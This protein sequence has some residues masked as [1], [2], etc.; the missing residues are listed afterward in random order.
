MTSNYKVKVNPASVGLFQGMSHKEA[1][2]W[3]LT[4]KYRMMEYSAVADTILLS[5]LYYL[6]T[7]EGYGPL[8]LR[9]AWEGM[10]RVRAVARVDM[11]ELSSGK[12]YKLEATGKNVEDFYMRE[13]LRKR[14]CDLK[15]WERDTRI[16]SEGVVIFGPWEP[17]AKRK[18]G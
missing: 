16:T 10:V 13:E 11:R 8:R 14:G 6:A 2:A 12:E 5:M 7:E 3:D 17:P 9:R 15:A 18:E 4:E 1:V